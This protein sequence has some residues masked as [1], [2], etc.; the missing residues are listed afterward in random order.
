MFYGLET[1]SADQAYGLEEGGRIRDSTLQPA[2]GRQL[3]SRGAIKR[4]RV[5]CLKLIFAEA[6]D[7]D[8]VPR[9]C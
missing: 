5:M 7:A 6:W 4:A 9:E 3:P 8:G 1:F 2:E